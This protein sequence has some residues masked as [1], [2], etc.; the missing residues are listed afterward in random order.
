MEEKNLCVILS[1]LAEEL[2]RRNSDIYILKLEN[3]HLKELLKKASEA[4]E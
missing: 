4:H 1:A 2:E 3:Q